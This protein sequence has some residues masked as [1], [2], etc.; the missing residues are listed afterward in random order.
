MIAHE[1][2]QHLSPN[3]LTVAHVVSPN[4]MR[5]AVRAG[6][7]VVTRTAVTAGLNQ[8]FEHELGER[9]VIMIRVC[10][11]LVDTLNCAPRW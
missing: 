11:G 3:V 4:T 10:P 7:D 1:I 6:A 8:D 5:T 2:A 9:S